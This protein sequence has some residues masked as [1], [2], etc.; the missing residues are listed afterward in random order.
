[1]EIQ[2][3]DLLSFSEYP[4]EYVGIEAKVVSISDDGVVAHLLGTD[5]VL[6]F[7]DLWGSWDSLGLF[8]IDRNFDGAN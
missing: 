3:G 2:I 4:S 8:K 1:M 7:G 5:K 6:V